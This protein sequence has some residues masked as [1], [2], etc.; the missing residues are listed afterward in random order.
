[1]KHDVAKPNVAQTAKALMEIYDCLH[2]AYGPQGWWPA[3]SAEEVVIGAILTQNTAWTNVEQ[4]IA[5]L[6]RAGRLTFHA[7]DGLEED[8][9]AELIRSAGTFR[10]KA[11]YLKSFARWLVEEHNGSLGAALSGELDSVRT[12]LLALKGIGPETADAIMLYA[13]NHPTF[14]VD[15]YTKRVLR[16]HFLIEP[17]QTDY[18]TVRGLFMDSLQPDVQ[19]FNEYHAL[20]VEVGKRHCKAVANC[21]GCP[22][23]HLEHEGSL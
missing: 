5:E 8:A 19:L 9:L 12:K 21:E 15:A 6:K 10:Q 13:G 17:E 14:V 11:A 16:R 2:K 4:A 1:M 23:A 22:L 18:E 3:D 20:F 7:I